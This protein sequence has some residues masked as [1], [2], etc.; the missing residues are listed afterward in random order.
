MEPSS[1][2]PL[3]PKPS[4]RKKKMARK[5]KAPAIP[6]PHPS[7]DPN[8][9]YAVGRTDYN[10]EEY[11]KV[12]QCWVD[13]SEDPINS[14]NQTSGKMWDRIEAR[15]NSV[16][17]SW[18]YKWS[19]DQLRKCWDRIKLHVNNFKDIYTKF[20]DKR[21]S[22]ESMEDVIQK[23]MATYQS[24]YG[25]FKFYNIWLILKDKPKFDGGIPALSL[26]AKRTKNTTTGGYTSSG[27]SPVDLNAKPEGSSGTP[28]STFRRP[29]SNKTAK[30]QAKG[31][32]TASG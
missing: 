10:M 22:G 4:M 15:Y 12:A 27:P 29:I 31:K 21:A 16:K 18:A 3:A 1:G 9:E 25:Q 32:A 7:N 14:N 24:K 17:P 20:R 6:V 11:M 8:D 23:S 2:Q 13:I 19:K 26:A 30:A 5:E 28:T